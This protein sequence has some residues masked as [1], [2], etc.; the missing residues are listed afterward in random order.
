MSM[1][2]PYLITPLMVV[3]HIFRKLPVVIL[4]LMEI[5]LQQILPFLML[6]LPR[7]NYGRVP[8]IPM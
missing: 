5:N 4:F 6:M 7:V 2:L 3:W 8:E 1:S